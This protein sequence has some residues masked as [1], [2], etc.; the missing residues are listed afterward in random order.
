METR[1]FEDVNVR[2]KHLWGAGFVHWGT[3]FYMGGGS[4][5]ATTFANLRRIS[6][7]GE[8]TELRAM[9]T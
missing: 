3:H 9:P 1:T 4:T 6:R 8:L 7:E 5:G 2:V